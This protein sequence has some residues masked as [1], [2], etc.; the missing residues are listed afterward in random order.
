M[1]KFMYKFLAIF[2]GMITGCSLAGIQI[3][4]I[5]KGELPFYG[6]RAF[7]QASAIRVDS[8]DKRLA[9]ISAISFIIC[10]IFTALFYW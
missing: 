5:V 9:L 3:R 8:L 6:Y 10:M 1:D 2:F 7:K 4:H